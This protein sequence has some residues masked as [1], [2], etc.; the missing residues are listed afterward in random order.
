MKWNMVRSRH[1]EAVF[2]PYRMIL[3]QKAECFIG[4]PFM[5]TSL[6]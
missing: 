1:E 2:P 3:A 5:V 6:L 4:F